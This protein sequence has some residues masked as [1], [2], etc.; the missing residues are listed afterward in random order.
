MKITFIHGAD[1]QYYSGTNFIDSEY[2]FLVRALSDHPD[3]EYTR[4]PISGE[5]DATC[6]GR[7][8]VGGDRTPDAV[9]L[10]SIQ[11]HKMPKITGL[12]S[13]GVPVLAKTG[14]IHDAKRYGSGAKNYDGW[15]VDCLFS[16]VPAPYFY[17]WYPA[18]MKYETIFYGIESS[19]YEDPPP[20]GLRIRDR[21]LL[22]GAADDPNPLARRMPYLRWIP[23]STRYRIKSCLVWA[24]RLTESSI[25]MWRKMRYP[26]PIQY[27]FYK[28]R[29]DCRLLPYVEDRVH[30][31]RNLPYEQLLYG[32]CAAIAATTVFPT[33]KYW[34]IAAA[35]C[36][37]FM[38]ITR[39]NYGECLG[40]RDGLN[41]VEIDEYNYREKFER[42]LEDP[43][44][45]AD[46]AAAGRRHALENFNN[47]VAADHLVSLIMKFI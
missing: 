12:K 46:V 5:F 28:L 17:E 23:R 42:F 15:G 29:T 22:S 20:Y 14:D 31:A 8:G 13:L 44:A 37:A 39:R 2:N 36:L 35:G 33:I 43:D 9:V 18:H 30:Y 21:I 1:D 7:G 40:F 38:E 6:L 41:C 16:S 27:Y 26:P 25:P 11:A 34:E 45:Y 47:D 19:L 32:Y 10:S 3:V 4:L 24:R